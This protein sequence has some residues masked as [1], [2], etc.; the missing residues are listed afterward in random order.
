V[1]RLMLPAGYRSPEFLQS[2]GVRPHLR[3]V[4]MV[5]DHHAAVLGP[6]D[7]VKLVV[8]PLHMRQG[9]Q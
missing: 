5:Q 3:V 1:L 9:L 8:V 4:Q 2:P 6:P 7:G